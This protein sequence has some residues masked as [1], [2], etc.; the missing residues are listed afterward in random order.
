MISY[1]YHH[2]SIYWYCGKHQYLLTPLIGNTIFH[3]LIGIDC[4]VW[5]PTT[6]QIFNHQNTHKH[7]ESIGLT[8]QHVV[9][10]G[11]TC[12]ETQQLSN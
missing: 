12:H 8:N 11:F 6:R 1:K 2:I 10:L 5:N 3:S 9:F 4:C 7:G